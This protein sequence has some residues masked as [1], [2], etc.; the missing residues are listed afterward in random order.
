MFV[1][2]GTQASHTFSS[3]GKKSGN[4]VDQAKFDENFNILAQQHAQMGENP[5]FPTENWKLYPMLNEDTPG[6]GFDRHYINHTAWAIRKLA[7]IA[8]PFHTDFGSDL[9]FA[10]LASALVPFRFYDFRPPALRLPNLEVFQGDLMALDIESGSLPSVSCMHVI[11]HIGLGR[12]GDTPDYNGDLAAMGELSRIVA[13][14][15]SLLIVVPM[16]TPRICYNAHRI[17]A[18]QQIMDAFAERFDLAEFSLIPDSGDMVFN[19]SKELADA[20]GFGCGCF[21]FTARA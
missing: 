9:Y 2:S 19:A 12:Y 6:T 18:Y 11:E 10:A 8:P 5:R 15:G 17:Y 21:H 3:F 16:G 13:P 1:E 7:Q 14:G 4:I 20:Q